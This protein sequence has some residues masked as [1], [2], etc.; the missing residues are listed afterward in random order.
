MGFG[1]AI[2]IRSQGVEGQPANAAALANSQRVP[3]AAC[4][5]QIST[6]GCD[7]SPSLVDDRASLLLWGDSFARALSPALTEYSRRA[8]VKVR[9]LVRPGC[10]PFFGAVPENPKVPSEPD[11]ECRTWLSE[12]R[13]RLGA[14]VSRLGLESFLLPDG[15]CTEEA[16]RNTAAVRCSIR[17]IWRFMNRGS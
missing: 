9:L 6:F 5:S 15:P 4:E 14:D 8:G 16:L 3:T 13:A 7:L 12:V 2:E 11:R 17:V 10:P 1:L